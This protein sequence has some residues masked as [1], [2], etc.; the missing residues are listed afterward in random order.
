MIEHASIFK[1]DRRRLYEQV[2]TA[3]VKEIESGKLKV[4]EQLP[5]EEELAANLGVSRTTLRTALS[6]LEAQSYIRR[7]QGRGTFVAD[8]KQAIAYPLDP[9]EPL[10]PCLAKASGLNSRIENI[11][12]HQ[13]I[14]E[15]TVASRLAVPVGAP[16]TE[17]SRAVYIDETPIGYLIDHVPDVVATSQE[18]REGYKG[19]V[20]DYF[21]GKKGRPLIASTQFEMRNARAG[22]IIGDFLK[23]RIGSII[24]VFDGVYFTA[25]GAITN[26]SLSYYCPERVSLRLERRK[27]PRHAD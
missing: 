24:L 22:E 11:R 6:I 25:D 17:V 10:H 9:L 27:V 12:I 8:K 7:V 21:D 20:I 19:S 13:I 5:R 15:A 1:R 26:C 4:G 18:L 23:M 16:V 14:A 3:I 2:Q